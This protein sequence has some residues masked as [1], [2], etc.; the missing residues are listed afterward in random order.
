[1]GTVNNVGGVYF[2]LCLT[3]ICIGVYLANWNKRATSIV[4][5]LNFRLSRH[6]DSTDGGPT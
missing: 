5:V 3:Y 4:R 6:T 2:N 1:M